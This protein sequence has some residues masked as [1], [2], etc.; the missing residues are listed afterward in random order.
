MEGVVVTAAT[1]TCKN[2]DRIEVRLPSFVFSLG[3]AGIFASRDGNGTN[4][5]LRHSWGII[6][7]YGITTVKM[8]INIQRGIR[9]GNNY[10]TR[11]NVSDA[12]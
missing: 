6:I 11:F 5:L 9:N 2:E 7:F 12:A 4:Y 1:T 8:V 3:D 10:P